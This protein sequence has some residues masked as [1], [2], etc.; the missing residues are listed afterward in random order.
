MPSLNEESL[1][2]GQFTD[3]NENYLEKGKPKELPTM[4][5]AGQQGMQTESK[6]KW[7]TKTKDGE[8]TEWEWQD[9]WNKADTSDYI[10]DELPTRLGVYM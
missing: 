1:A 10:N 5:P 6:N 3:L 8:L 4:G 7:N 2:D 9:R